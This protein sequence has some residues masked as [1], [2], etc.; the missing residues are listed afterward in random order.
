VVQEEARERARTTAPGSAA[1]ERQKRVAQLMGAGAAA[2]VGMTG[3]RAAVSRVWVRGPGRR[4]AGRGL[5]GISS[6]RRL[7]ETLPVRAEPWR[8]SEPATTMWASF[9]LAMA[10]ATRMLDGLF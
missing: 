9:V 10:D 1:A 3:A 6:V 7:A 8:A 4:R 2:V 5:E